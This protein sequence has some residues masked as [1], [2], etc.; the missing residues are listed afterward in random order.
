ML[1][2]KWSQIW[3][4]PPTVMG[5]KVSEKRQ[6]GFL[7][8]VY[9]GRTLA[10]PAMI[11]RICLYTERRNKGK[12]KVYHSMCRGFKPLFSFFL[13]HA[14]PQ[15]TTGQFFIRLSLFL[16]RCFFPGGTCASERRS[17]RILY[18]INFFHERN[19]AVIY[20]KEFF[21][22]RLPGQWCPTGSAVMYGLCNFEPLPA[23]SFFNII[24]SIKRRSREVDEVECCWD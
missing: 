16:F 12:K 3:Q 5:Y 22:F 20:H 7:L 15:K 1:A 11:S 18:P 14:L 24:R 4:L 17:R 9:S 23:F 10:A 6:A 13:P 21:P 2:L 19:K 8:T